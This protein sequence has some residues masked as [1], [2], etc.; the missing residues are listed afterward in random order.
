MSCYSPALQ[1]GED[2]FIYGKLGHFSAESGLFRTQVVGRSIAEDL[3]NESQLSKQDYFET[4][5][6]SSGCLAKL[7]CQ[8]TTQR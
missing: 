1:R 4:C 3:I 7:I 5:D 8:D 2:K 6:G